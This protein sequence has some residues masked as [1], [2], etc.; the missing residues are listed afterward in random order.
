MKLYFKLALPHMVALSVFFLFSFMFFSPLFQGYSLKQQDVKQ[1]R[2]MSKEILDHHVTN[3]TD[4]LWT[5]SMFGGMPAY[6]ILVHHKNNF[7]IYV[8]SVL[9]MGLP[10]MA[11]LLFLMMLGFYIFA[12]CLRINPW[13]SILAAVAYGFSTINI[14][15]LGAGHL[16][17][18]KTI[19]YIA[20]VLGGLI[21]SFRGKILLGATIFALFL[22]LNLMANHP[23]MTYYLGFLCLFIGLGELIRLSVFEKQS[24]KAILYP[25]FALIFGAVLA[26][27]SNATNLMTT[28]EYGEFTTRGP[29]ELT[30]EPDGSEKETAQKSGLNSDYILE[31]NYGNG[32]LLSM[33]IPNARGEKGGVFGNDEELM[34]YIADRDVDKETDFAVDQTFQRQNRYWGG[35]RFSGGAFYFG[36]VLFTLFVFGIVFIKDPIKWPIIVLAILAMLLSSNDPDGIN[37]YFINHFPLYNKFRDSKMILVLLQVVIP[38]IALL[39]VD[40]LFKKKFSFDASKKIYFTGG[41]LLL[42]FALMFMIPGLSGDFISD[43]ESK[44]FADTLKNQPEAKDY[45]FGLKSAMKDARIFLFKQDAMRALGLCVLTLLCLFYFFKR[46]SAIIFVGISLGVLTIGDNLTVS[47][48]YL[49]LS[50]DESDM[51]I[52]NISNL[53]SAGFMDED[54]DRIAYLQFEPNDFALLPPQMPSVADQFILA[55]E[56]A[57]IVDFEDKKAKFLKGMEKHFYYSSLENTKLKNLIADYGVLNQ[58]SNYRVFTLNNPF[59]ESVT[60]YYHKS[61]GGYHGA[62]LKRYQ[63]LIDFR[64]AKE[65]AFVQQNI[66]QFGLSVF[67]STPTLNMMNTRYVILNPGGRPVQ[68][69][70]AMGNAWFV[71]NLKRVNDANSEIISLSD[72]ALNLK[73]TAVVH[74]EFK[75]LSKVINP[76]SSAS[77]R[78]TSYRPNLIK[79]VASSTSTQHA[80]FSEIYY[81]KGWNCYINGNLTSSFRANYILRGVTIPKGQ[82]N[83]EWRFEPETYFK[84]KTISLFSSIFLLI[85]C[86]FIFVKELLRE[87]NRSL[88]K[89]DESSEKE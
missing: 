47:K 64:I 35:Q 89:S 3:D 19:A 7:L 9:K 6:Q 37:H 70:Y 42:F 12:L 62:K 26:L 41:A 84:S 49:D 76:D 53:V 71:G 43:N 54:E 25:V 68:N 40:G 38:M 1:Y 5:N 48:R 82:N 22:G 86:A 77:I 79:Y 60:S 61:I 14:L 51:E 29:T 75:N 28:L 36:V 24:F 78:M 18:V 10:K 85:I 81:P 59:A 2:G 13:L 23:Q 80:I 17:K 44:M 8:D 11:N 74:N 16:T 72:S 63:E 55:S 50:V 21:L 73:N 39:F 65:A 69:P 87:I 83:I 4:P 34:D 52:D 20:P 67:E 66:N 88:L 46:R 27:L 58:N 45:L 31:Y 30:V 33:L 56:S 32:E 15:Y 57:K